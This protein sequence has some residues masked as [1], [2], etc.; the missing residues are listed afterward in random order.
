[1]TLLC[2]SDHTFM[3]NVMFLQNQGDNVKVQLEILCPVSMFLW[4]ALYLAYS[5]FPGAVVQT[6]TE[7]YAEL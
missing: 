6:L 5:A 1:M 7:K 4:L 3:Y 2:L